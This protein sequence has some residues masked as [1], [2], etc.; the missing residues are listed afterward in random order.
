MKDIIED[1]IAFIK[2]AIKFIGI[3]LILIGAFILDSAYFN[4]LI[5]AW[6]LDN[7]FIVSVGIWMLIFFG[8]RKTPEDT[9]ANEKWAWQQ[10]TLIV[11]ALTLINIFNKL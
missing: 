5:S 6:V 2:D 10:A 11:I 8:L 1:L 4:A 3:I 9:V 7:W